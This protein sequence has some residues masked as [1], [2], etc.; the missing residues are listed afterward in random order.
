MAIDYASF[1]TKLGKQIDAYKKLLIAVGGTT[2]TE[3]QQI[4]DAYASESRAVLSTIEG[5]ISSLSSLQGSVSSQISSLLTNPMSS[6]LIEL[7]KDDTGKTVSRLQALDEL[8][9]QMKADGESVESGTV[10]AAVTGTTTGTGSKETSLVNVDGYQAEL[11]YAEDI[12]LRLQ[13]SGAGQSY[14]IIGDI[15][16]SR[17]NKDYPGGSG[18]RVS[19][20]VANPE[21]S[22][23]IVTN[24]TLSS[25]SANDATLPEG[26]V[27]TSSTTAALS[28]VQQEQ[29]AISG[30][31][32]A[33]HYNIEITDADGKKLVT[34]PL[35]YNALA[36]ALQAAVQELPGYEDTTVTYFSGSSPNYTFRV[37]F[38][39]RQN[40]NVITI[41]DS[42][43]GGTPVFTISTIDAGG[44]FLS[45]GRCLTI[46]GNGTEKVVYY[47]PVNLSTRTAYF[48]SVRL[49]PNT[50]TSGAVKVSLVDQFEAVTD[51]IHDNAGNDNA[52]DTDV[53][54]LNNA[55]YYAASGFFRTPTELPSAVYLKIEFTTALD[56]AGVVE[57]SDVL[58]KATSPVYP[59]G[60]YIELTDLET[61]WAKDDRMVVTISNDYAGELHQWMDR[62]FSLKG[63]GR[64]LPT[65]GTPTRPDSLIS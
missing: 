6:L 53:S 43:T 20:R 44:N 64:L 58:L 59:G 17:F 16:Y 26:W 15:G 51:P 32:S 47:I 54:A 29:I 57:I 30:T 31:P 22:G 13:G 56:A 25:V 2:D 50:V 11:A 14:L 12:N 27:S 55:E 1:F 48:A 3:F 65:S 33:G 35:A 42:T 28:A 61:E 52:Y 7:V 60:P 24:G 63:S 23:N 41:A 4:L 62:I 10:S 34:K 46:T 36:G 45:G 49:R 18:I 21:S 5:T 40:G 8:I 38:N 9:R 37:T 39:N 19:K